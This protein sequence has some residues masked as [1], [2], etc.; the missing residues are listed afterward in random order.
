MLRGVVA[1]R[2]FIYLHPNGKGFVKTE[3]QTTHFTDDTAF[4]Q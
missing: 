2:I 4:D 3:K 1:Y